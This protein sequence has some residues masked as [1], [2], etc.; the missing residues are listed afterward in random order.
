MTAAILSDMTGM[1]HATVENSAAY[2]QNW[3]SKLDD[4]PKMLVYAGGAAQ[5]AVD[6]VVEKIRAEATA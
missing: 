3:L 5:K 4:D 2:I 1:N 6:F